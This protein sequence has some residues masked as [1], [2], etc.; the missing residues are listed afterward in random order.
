MTPTTLEICFER[1][2]SD[3]IS[4]ADSVMSVATRSSSF[5]ARYT[6]SRPVV[7][8]SLASSEIW[9]A[10]LALS[11][12]CVMLTDSCSTEAAIP[13]AEVEAWPEDSRAARAASCS[14]SAATPTWVE[15]DAT[16]WTR[17]R[18]FSAM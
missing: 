11:A 12:T 9:A 1:S 3:S 18:M 2:P 14:S 17:E 6:T 5:M 4:T 10:W 13:D 15:V 7:V 8:T 16:P